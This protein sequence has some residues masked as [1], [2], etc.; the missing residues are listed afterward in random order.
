[1]NKKMN[2]LQKLLD[3]HPKAGAGWGIY[4]GIC[5][6]LLSVVAYITF[7]NVDTS[8]TK[9]HTHTENK[10]LITG[11][12]EAPFITAD[13]AIVWDVRKGEAVYEKNA[14]RIKPLASITKVMT[15]L[16]A[17]EHVPKETT[18][19]I[20]TNDLKQD[21]DSGLVAGERWALKDLIDFSLVESSNDGVAAVAGAV[22]ALSEGLPTEKRVGR[23][24]FIDMMNTKAQE[25][26]LANMTF[27]NES[28]LDIWNETEAGSYG[29]AEDVAK[30]FSYTLTTHPDIFEVTTQDNQFFRSLSGN[31]HLAENTNRALSNIPALIA[32]KTG[33]TDLSGGNLGVIVDP[34]INYPFV[35]VVL[36][37]TFE[38]RFADV[39]ALSESTLQYLSPE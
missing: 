21:G 35:I 26:G 30:L 29:T 34:G 7:S 32:S 36:G 22:G 4:L 2:K 19:I 39:V 12:F 9:E 18:V 37:S 14:Q 24:S 10:P 13:S 5:I 33:Y 8:T 16:I 25:L 38:D 15:A 20:D 3:K 17:M 6:I 28:G 1:M 11:T 31:V 27:E 23:V